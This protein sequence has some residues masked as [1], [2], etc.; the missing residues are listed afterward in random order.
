MENCASV[1]TPKPPPRPYQEHDASLGSSSASPAHSYQRPL[2]PRRRYHDTI[3]QLP[4]TAITSGDEVR[5]EQNPTGF[6][7]FSQQ[8]ALTTLQD[9]ENGIV[10]AWLTGFRAF[11]PGGENWFQPDG[12]SAQELEAISALKDCTD[13]LISAWLDYIRC[14][15]QYAFCLSTISQTPN[16]MA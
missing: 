15:G 3:N 12:L 13:S 4:T 2:Q 10:F 9:Y 5:R 16:D 11:R 8:A 14:G 7:S 6:P 1:V